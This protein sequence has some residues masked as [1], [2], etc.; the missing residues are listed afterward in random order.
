LRQ[1][2][3]TRESFEQLARTERKLAKSP[4]AHEELSAFAVE[5]ADH[6]APRLGEQAQTLSQVLEVPGPPEADGP[7]SQV[8]SEAKPH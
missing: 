6:L 2:A 3:N 1:A 7:A 4:G 5:L 8:A